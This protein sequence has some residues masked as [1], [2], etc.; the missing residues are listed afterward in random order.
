VADQQSDPCPLPDTGFLWIDR[1]F[2]E[3]IAG[4]GHLAT[5]VYV[6]L[7]GHADAKR[8]CFP[9]IRTITRLCGA[10]RRSVLRAVDALEEA[11]LVRVERRRAENGS[12]LSNVYTLT[13]L[14]PSDSTKPPLVTPG[15][16]NK[17]QLEQEPLN[18][19]KKPATAG[20]P[21]EDLLALI[22]LWNGLKE[23]IIKPGNGARRDPPSQAAAKGWRRAMRN[24]EQRA[25]FRDLAAI[26]TA[27]QAADFCHGQPWFRIEW[28]FGN[29]KTGEHNI[30]KLLA[31]G[32]ERNGNGT[33]THRPSA[34]GRRNGTVRAQ[35]ANRHRERDY[36]RPPTSP[37]PSS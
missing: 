18:K 12:H 37:P 14:D 6:I 15:N 28:L 34:R 24:P 23:G 19:K 9:S 10:A 26:G 35:S 2:V 20:A 11:G 21:P 27:I 32:Y 7:A 13:P 4:V 1:R 25:A 33:G 36:S 3:T 5:S 30:V 31:G 17:N 16:H 29:N 8:Q 22:D